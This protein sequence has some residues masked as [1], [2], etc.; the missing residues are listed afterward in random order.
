MTYAVLCLRMPLIIALALVSAPAQ[1]EQITLVDRQT[2]FQHL[3]VIEDT[4]RHERY[5]Y[6]DDQRYLQGM[7]LLR[8]PD[9]LEPGYLR[10]AL[11]GLVFAPPEPSSM[12]FVGLGAGSLPRYLSARYPRARLDAVEIDPEVPPIARRYFALP[13]AR[14]LRV[15]VREGREFIRGQTEKYDLVLMDA[16]FGGEI[17]LHLATLEFMDE[18]R[19]VLQPGGI[20]VANLPAPEVAANVWSVVATYR[21]GFPHVRTF[22]TEH[23]ASFILLASS[24]DLWPGTATMRQRIQQLKS[25]HRIDVDLGA[26]AALPPPWGNAPTAAP[27]LRD[28]PQ[29]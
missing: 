24:A 5:L 17:P 21:A 27:E 14:N 9:R 4:K 10:S 19:R 26:L 2:K 6:S 22:A 8:R 13:A 18:L 23:P 12:L 25:R 28:A 1:A 16:Y 7:I 3:P 11:L 20:V 29:R 15:I